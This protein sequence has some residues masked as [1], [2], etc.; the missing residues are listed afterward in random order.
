M[1]FL[2]FVALIAGCT[3]S[4]GY[5][6]TELTR[7]DKEAVQR[8][9]DAYLADPMSVQV[10]DTQVFIA[11]NGNRMV[12]GKANAKNAFGGYI[13]YQ[14]FVMIRVAGV[15]YSQPYARPVFALG[16]EAQVDCGGAGYRL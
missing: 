9:F 3:A 15:D 8:S 16:I 5:K 2:V 12:C 11:D 13:G 6:P 10:K 1:R 4:Q 14:T 7:A